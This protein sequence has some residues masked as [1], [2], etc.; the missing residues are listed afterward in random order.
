[1]HSLDSVCKIPT[2][3]RSAS[4]ATQLV[5]TFIEKFTDLSLPTNTVDTIEKRYVMGVICGNYKFP[6]YC[7]LQV[8][9]ILVYV[10][11]WSRSDIVN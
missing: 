2:S 10:S 3:E 11:M 6:N 8:A 4:T 5:S 9:L 7:Y 1:M